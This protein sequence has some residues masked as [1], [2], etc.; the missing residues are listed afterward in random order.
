MEEYSIGKRFKMFFSK[1]ISIKILIIL[2]IATFLTYKGVLSGWHWLI[3]VIS[4]VAARE[5]A[6]AVEK[7]NFTK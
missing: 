7:M 6:H 3:V 2:P 1:L 4:I 5:F